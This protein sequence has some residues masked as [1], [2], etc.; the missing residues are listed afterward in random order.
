ML[1]STIDYYDIGTTENG[2]ADA[3]FAMCPNYYMNES[4]A[5]AARAAFFMQKNY[6]KITHFNSPP[7]KLLFAEVVSVV[8]AMFQTGDRLYFEYVVI[9]LWFQKHYSTRQRIELA[10]LCEWV[11]KYRR[12]H[13][14]YPKQYIMES[15]RAMIPTI[16]RIV[17]NV[18]TG[19][20]WG[21]WIEDAQKLRASLYKPGYEKRG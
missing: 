9:P 21:K 13:P 5:A 17:E 10:L 15:A 20:V 16:S 2:Y 7:G 8:G 14:D 12:K 18:Q 1:N 6:K 11:H 19:V 4:D 3:L